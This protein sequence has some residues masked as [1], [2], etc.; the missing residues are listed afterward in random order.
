[1]LYYWLFS[2]ITGYLTYKNAILLVIFY[3]KCYIAGY[4][5]YKNVILLVI[6]H[7][8]MLY[9]KLNK[10]LKLLGSV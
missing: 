6:F 3:I 8:K 10:E 2:Y 9:G 1:M 5:P 7:I 4:I